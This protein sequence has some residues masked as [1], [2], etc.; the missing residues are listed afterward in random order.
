[1]PPYIPQARVV[2]KGGVVVAPPPVPLRER[3]AAVEAGLGPRA[4]GFVAA[5]FGLWPVTAVLLLSLGLMWLAMMQS[6]P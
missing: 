4:R 3:L 5:V 2:R 6:S 1:M